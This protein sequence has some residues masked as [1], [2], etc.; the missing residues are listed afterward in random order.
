MSNRSFRIPGFSKVVVNLSEKVDEPG[1]EFGNNIVGKNTRDMTVSFHLPSKKVRTVLFG[2]C[3][4]MNRR[5]REHS[6]ANFYP[7]ASMQLEEAYFIISVA[8][9]VPSLEQ[10]LNN[11]T[12]LSEVHL[13]R[14]G[15]VEGTLTT[16][17]EVFFRTV[18]I[19][20]L[21]QILDYIAVGI[22]YCSIETTI[23]AYA[24]DGK[25]RGKTSTEISTISGVCVAK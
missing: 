5:T 18:Y 2:Y 4:G 12:K 11:G 7:D 17:T 13:A 14:W 3:F 22:K 6:T 8:K 9:T 24:Q 15:W 23:N 19:V 16:L 10:C 20:H 21:V 1:N 25:S